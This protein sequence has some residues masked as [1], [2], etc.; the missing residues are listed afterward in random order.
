MSN[1][2]LPYRFEDEKRQ[3]VFTRHDLP[4][5]WI[6][7]LSNGKMH[8]FVSQAGGGMCWW[9]TSMNCRITRYRFYNLPID[10]PGFYIYIRMAD[11]TVWSPT[12]RP[13]ETQ[14]DSWQAVHGPGYTAFAAEKDGLRAE[15]TLFTAQDS[16]TLI[17]DVKLT[18]LTEK[19]LQA[20]VFTYTEFSQLA[21]ENEF[22]LGYYLKWNTDSRYEKAPESIIYRYTSWMQVDPKNAPLVYFAASE[23]PHSFCCNRDLFC[24]NYRDERNPIQVE[25]GRLGNQNMAGGEPCGALHHRVTLA[26]G[27]EKP[28]HYFLGV[29]P[30]ALTDPAGAMAQTAKTLQ[31]LR[32]PGAVQEQ[33][34]KALSWWQKHLDIYQADIPDENACRMINT[35]NP[36]QSVA[37]ARYSRSIS[38]SASGIRGIGFRDSAQDM[39]AQAYRKPEWATEML[40]YLASQQMED[41]HAVHACWP[42][43]GKLPQDLTRSDD[44]IWMTYLAYAI[45][46]ESGDLSILDKKIPFLDKD[47]KTPVHP[48]SLWEHLLRGVE[49]TENHL[50][51]HGLPLILFS[52]WNDHMGPFGRKG[53]GETLFV[54]EQHIYA[55]A[56]LIELAE[57]RGEKETGKRLQALREKQIQAL[58]QY[59]WDGKWYLRGLDDETQPIG[60]QHSDWAKIWVNAQSWMIIAGCGDREKNLSAMDAVKE[61]LDTGLG[62]QINA[63]GMPAEK[64]NN[65]PAG[66]SENGGIFCQ[67]NCWAII[68]EA[69]LGRGDQ[70]WAYYRQ[71]IPHNIIQRIGVDAYRGESYA[72]SSTLLG[73]ENEQFGQACVSQVTGTAAWMDVAATQY[74]LGIRPSV[75]GLVIDPVL[76][77]DWEGFCVSRHYR[78]CEL[79]VEVKKPVGV[80]HGVKRVTLDGQ[81][82]QGNLILPELLK[83]KHSAHVLV[84]M[85]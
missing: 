19:E 34:D 71:L 54:S 36:I 38:S 8:A 52:D 65:L 37:T 61:K 30:G 33:L 29:T 40:Y 43:D 13:C 49:F 15:L 75:K 53:K 70:A 78:G 68:A 51:A 77:A 48:V 56:Q 66:Y 42:D 18:N 25:N 17:W 7:Y 11:G 57:L 2:P 28:L 20:D 41:G 10:S 79:R 64:A 27:S 6:N 4:Q 26:A 14:L 23:T 32:N 22:K 84:E 44:H 76:P 45:I 85:G 39:L 83:G 69:L 9:K 62:L 63:P 47:Y 82:V 1:Q 50:G 31:T 72:Y 3:I 59:S 58:R 55:L 35:W 80:Q 60:S 16:D 67:A 46:A 12:F 5:P 81:P 74:L 24:G 21:V 73:P